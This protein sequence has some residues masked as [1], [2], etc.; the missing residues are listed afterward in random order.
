MKVFR[1]SILILFLC[2]LYCY[3]QPY[4]AKKA[5]IIYCGIGK[6]IYS[7][8]GHIGI[9]IMSETEDN[10]YNFGTFDPSTPQFLPRYIRGN[11]DYTLS[12]ES[13]DQFIRSYEPQGRTVRAYE[14][15][16]TNQEVDELETKL[17]N[18][19]NSASRYYQYQFLANNCS[20]RVFELLKSVL[21][22]KIIPAHYNLNSTYR[23][24]LN[25]VLNYNPAYRFPV[26]CLLGSLG[27]EKLSISANTY[28]PDSLI[29]TLSETK[30]SAPK[31]RPLIGNSTSILQATNNL[32]TSNIDYIIVFLILIIVI[33]SKSRYTL[34]FTGICGIIIV[35]L[36]L[37]SDR[38]EFAYNYNILL[39]NPFDLLLFFPKARKRPVLLFSILLNIV[40]IGVFMA[41][42][43]G[44]LPLIII[45]LALIYLKLKMIA[46]SYPVYYR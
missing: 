2:P 6:E 7:I 23:Q 11:L 36:M 18:L 16:L 10:V 3:C 24:S 27:E 34:L 19:Y 46:P 45:N 30:L 39:F 29:K 25:E 44:Y 20:T 22:D 33:W 1:L 15:L 37:Y 40:Y 8:F 12:V 38:Q 35:F 32:K 42:S 31:H 43:I 9:R 28:L 26:N 4:K 41:L 17:H 5:S 14:L 13:Y 21:G